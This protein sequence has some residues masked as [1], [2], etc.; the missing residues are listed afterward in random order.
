MVLLTAIGIAFSCGA[1]VAGLE[2]QLHGMFRNAEDQL[3]RA[4]ALMGRGV[5][6]QLAAEL[7]EPRGGLLH[8]RRPAALSGAPS[9]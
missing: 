2:L 1:P 6:P 8:L 4:L 7:R 5:D 9:G 3:D